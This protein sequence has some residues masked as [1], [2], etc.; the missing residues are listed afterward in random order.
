MSRRPTATVRVLQRPDPA[1]DALRIEVQCRHSVTGLTSLGRD[2]I[3]LTVPMLVTSACFAHEEKCGR[4]DTGAAHEQGDR[5]VRAATEE[6]W[7]HLRV[8]MARRL[9]E[10]RRN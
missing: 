9:L 10:G 4:C 7:D 1:P 3:G 6:A 8:E 2:R 5:A